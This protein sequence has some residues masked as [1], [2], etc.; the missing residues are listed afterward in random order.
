MPTASRKGNPLMCEHLTLIKN[1]RIVSEER[2]FITLAENEDATNIAVPPGPVLVPLAVWTA[3]RAELLPRA[4]AGELGIWLAAGEDPAALAEDVAQLSLIALHFPKF[5]DGRSYSTAT[6]LRQRFGYRG[7]L[8]AIGEVL[9]DQFNYLQ[10]CGFDALQPP[11]GRY[12]AAQLEAALASFSD[13]SQPYQRSVTD[14]LPLFRRVE[15]SQP[16]EVSQ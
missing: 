3:R 9:R 14:P 10:R 16:S 12:S 6:L 4:V 5:T 7:E 1:G 8:R 15:R 13:F 11:A 2:S